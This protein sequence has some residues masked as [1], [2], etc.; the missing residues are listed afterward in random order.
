M[1]YIERM[2]DSSWINS[3]KCSHCYNEWR[4]E[5]TMETLSSVPDNPD[6]FKQSYINPHAALLGSEVAL[7]RECTLFNQLDISRSDDGSGDMK[8]QYYVLFT[9]V[10]MSPAFWVILP[11][12]FEDDIL[13]LIS[14]ICICTCCFVGAVMFLIGCFTKVEQEMRIKT[15][16]QDPFNLVPAAYGYVFFI[17]MFALNAL[18]VYWLTKLYHERGVNAATMCIAMDLQDEISNDCVKVCVHLDQNL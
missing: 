3:R 16:H 2:P 8:N 15:W 1:N 6:P 14:I 5:V 17:S 4:T 9:G 7:C 18:N 13:V 10:F 12:A 11:T